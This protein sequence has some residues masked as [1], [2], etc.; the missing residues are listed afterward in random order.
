MA[1]TA[2]LFPGQGSQVPDMRDAVAR[3]R[4]DLLA[5]CAECVGDDPFDRV[6]EGTRWA[7]PAIFTASLA[8]ASELPDLEP[9][10]LAGH[11][12]GEIAALTVAGALREPDAMRIVALRG[13]LMQ[14]AGERH[15]DGTM[16]ALLGAGAAD[17]AP[18]IA[19]PL[20]L[21]VANDNAPHQV[22]LSGDR[23]SLQRAAEA[24]QEQ[25]LRAMPLPVAGAFHSPFMAGATEAFKAALADTAVRT[26]RTQV[27]SMVT[28]QPFDDIRRRLAEA[29]ERPVRFREAILHLHAQG[30]RRFVEVG[31]G[32]VLTGL[33][34]RTIPDG[35]ALT[36]DRL[37]RAV[38]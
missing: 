36:A 12:L 29:L 17:K 7:Q 2:L 19:E 35:E 34:K 33:V 25:G 22:V 14:D 6:E 31:P 10:A 37:E 9:V 27:I 23:T 28:A 4:P 8:A 1:P 16:L 11:S 38:A 21:T 26:P 18:A 3:T 30:V 32:R 20:D 15:G 24:A 13:R 5:L